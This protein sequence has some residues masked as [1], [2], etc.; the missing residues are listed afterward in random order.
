M[1]VQI[2]DLASYIWKEELQESNT[3]TIP[4]IAYWIR[5]NGIGQLNDL[6]HTSF[7]VDDTTLEI[8]PSNTFSL[9]AA[10]ILVQIYMIK[11]YKR[12]SS[13]FLGAVGISDTIEY[14]ENG[15]VIRKLNRTEQ[16]K[17]WLEL[18]K[19]AKEDLKNLVAGYKISNSLSLSIEGQELNLLSTVLP[20]YNRSI[21]QGF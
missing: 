5:M 1:N 17:T 2:T 3:T 14:S 21:N 16:S 15:M 13:I 18:A 6:I 7:D 9:E 19:Q 12:Q 11:H 4:E 10:A 8:I 20:K